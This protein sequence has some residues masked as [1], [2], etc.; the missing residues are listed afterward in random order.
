M[1]AYHDGVDWLFIRLE[2]DQKWS[3]CKVEAMHASLVSYMHTRH[4]LHG[5]CNRALCVT[6]LPACNCAPCV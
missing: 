2:L 5:L 1:I 6:V 4:T 3:I